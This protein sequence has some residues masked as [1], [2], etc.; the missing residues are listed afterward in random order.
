MIDEMRKLSA[1]D[2]TLYY[3]QNNQDFLSLSFVVEEFQ[4]RAFVS[5]DHKAI[6]YGN[7]SIDAKLQSIINDYLSFSDGT[8]FQSIFGDNLKIGM[9]R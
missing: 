8:S 3:K 9:G 6:Q 7:N 1:F 2:K 4:L 5:L